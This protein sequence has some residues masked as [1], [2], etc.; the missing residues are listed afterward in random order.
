MRKYETVFILEPS[1]DNEGIE[2]KINRFNETIT[3]NGGNILKQDKWGL[4]NL[5]YP[6]AK[7]TQGYYAVTVFEGKGE[8][9]AELERAYRL[10]EQVLRH[11][12]IVMDKKQ[13]KVFEK[14]RELAAPA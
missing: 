13:Q 7:K 5:A 6:I 2:A 1:L 10:D 14:S 11:L 9:L 4:R 3:A 12:T 8:T